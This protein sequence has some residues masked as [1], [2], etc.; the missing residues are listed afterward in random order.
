MSRRCDRRQIKMRSRQNGA[1]LRPAQGQ[2]DGRGIPDGQNGPSGFEFGPA[3]RGAVLF[4]SVGVKLFDMHVLIIQIGRGQPP[5][6][7]FG[8]AQK[9]GRHP[10]NGCA[11]HAARS[12]LQPRQVPHTGGCE[13]Q[14]GIIGKQCAARC[15][16]VRGGCPGVRCAAHIGLRKGGQRQIGQPHRICTG[17]NP[18]N[19]IGIVGQGGN[20]WTGIIGQQVAHAGIGQQQ[21][22]AGA[23]DFRCHMRGLLQGHQ[24][25]DGNRI[26]RLPD[27][28]LGLEQEE[29][30]RAPA[31]R[32]AVDLA[33]PGIDA[34]GI[35]RK[36]A[37]GRCVLCVGRFQSQP[38]DVV[39]AQDFVDADGALA[40]NLGQAPLRGAAKLRHL[41]Q[42]VLGMGKAQREV[43][44]FIRGPE[45]MGHIGI[46]AHNLDRGRNAGKREVFGVIGQRARQ[47]I[48]ADDQAQKAQHDKAGEQPQEPAEG[49]DHGGPEP[50]A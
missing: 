25:E 10:R 21:R 9:N 49:N 34:T 41:P 33:D 44:I 47:E 22:G 42:T 13:V 30:G 36:R 29:L 8:P 4:R 17:Q 16:P 40:E 11:D 14:V 46:V 24:L 18:R 23:P 20:A 43:D 19:K 35:G 39:A 48:I 12:Q 26:R 1:I 6:H 32:A 31:A 3:L 28:D 5:A 50:G 27:G 7:R 45:D 2:R 37:F 38:V 15:R